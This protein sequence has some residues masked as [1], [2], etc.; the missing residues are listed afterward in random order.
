[1]GNGRPVTVDPRRGGQFFGVVAG[2]WGLTLLVIATWWSPWSVAVV[3][4]LI[5]LSIA[6][7]ID[8]GQLR[9]PDE[10]VAA[11]MLPVVISLALAGTGQSD[12][13]A[14]VAAGA[15][16]AGLPLLALHLASPAAMGFGD[17]KFGL[18]LGAVLGLVDHRLGLAAVCLGSAFAAGWGLIARRRAVPLG[19]GLMLGAMAAL[20]LARLTGVQV[21]PWR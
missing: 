5:P 20:T 3:A 17:V 14:S 6:A 18:A 19:P 2:V 13:A 16:M 12:V 4:A 21:P 7:W 8:L 9:L 15:V 11:S 10:L 1:M